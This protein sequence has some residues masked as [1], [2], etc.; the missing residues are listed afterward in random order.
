[1]LL[2]ALLIYLNLLD[3]C[4]ARPRIVG[5]R[6]VNITEYPYQLSLRLNNQHI[7]GAVLIS[8]L[9]G[10]SAAHCFVV[11]GSY[12]VRAGSSYLT[13]GGII[14]PVITAILHPHPDPRNQN[15]DIAIL[16]FANRL[17]FSSTIQPI[18]LPE[19]DETPMPGWLGVVSGWGSTS[20]QEATNAT[21]TLR[22]VTIPVEYPE[23]CQ[24]RY[25]YIHLTKRMFCAGYREG[26]KDSCQGDSGG[27]FVINGKL[28]G[29]ISWGYFCA[30]SGYPGVYTNVGAF[31]NYINLNSGV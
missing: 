5:G 18:S 25:S 21:K 23:W 28:F 22:A 27:P 7:C 8:D 26:G 11:R 31:R 13:E 24:S 14:V 6:E 20:N 9:Y 29:I 30:Q 12:T 19:Q 4:I 10:L 2:L 1:M 15:N 17:S 3:D 16:K